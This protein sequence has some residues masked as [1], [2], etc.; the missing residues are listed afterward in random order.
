MLVS[1]PVGTSLTSS[2][3]PRRHDHA[4][5]GR[6]AH[7]VIGRLLGDGPRQ[8]SPRQ[9]LSYAATEP[10][11][12]ET[13]VYRLAA[14]ARVTALAAIYFRYFAPAESWAFVKASVSLSPGDLDLVFERVPSGPVRADELKTGADDFLDRDRLDAQI[15]R[16]LAG[17]REKYAERFAGI[18]VLSLSAP[19]RS[20]LVTPAG[21]R[22]PLETRFFHA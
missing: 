17:G 4:A 22:Q 14:R 3:E 15:E 13:G 7:S 5:H 2:G 16:E 1:S 21:E 10:L 19:S 11:L 18:R 12:E 9:L 6:A 20:L 8:P